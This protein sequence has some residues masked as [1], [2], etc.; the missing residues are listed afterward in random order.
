MTSPD[1]NRRGRAHK[2]GPSTREPIAIVGI[3]CRFPGDAKSPE[4][5]W[6]LLSQGVNAVTQVPPDRWQIRAFYDLD[7]TKPGKTYVRSGGFINDIDLFD[8]G[9]FGISP[10]EASRM[11][12][13][14]R[15]LLEVAYEAL[16]DG[17]IA[18]ER[19]AGS[20]G[21]V[22]IGIS[23]SDYGGIQTAVSE[24][25]LI[26][27][28]TNIGLGLCISANRISYFF[29]LHGPSFAVDTACSSSL[30][31]VHLACQSIWN[32]ECEMA[33]TGGVNAILRPEGTIG[34][35]KAS[36]LSSTGTCKT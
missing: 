1:H 23:S 27:A 34:F 25:H 32:G 16:E 26:S 13:Q 35:S 33:F 21:G 22:F 19:I 2:S 9:F 36:M 29:D 12:P 14:H 5:F 11:D 6:E 28:Y 17:G 8:E 30:V 20:N 3:G 15:L 18:P 7:P 24:R 4:D 31:A 10:R